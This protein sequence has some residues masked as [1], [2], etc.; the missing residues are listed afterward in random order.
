MS[1]HLHSIKVLTL[2]LLLAFVCL[3]QVNAQ[4][5]TSSV[6]GTAT[7][8][9]GILP[10]AVITLIHVP[11]GTQYATIANQ[12]GQFRLEGLRTGGPYRLEATYVGHNKTIVN[13]QRLLLGDV[14]EYDVQLEMENNL[15]EVVVAGNRA[16]E[17][18]DGS[19][20]N[21]SAEELNNIPS[22]DRRIEDVLRFSPYYQDG[23][24][25]SSLN[26]G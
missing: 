12:K 7:D 10:G 18:K 17:R 22:T 24:V 11:S 4:S 8:A 2:T 9:D 3:V 23:G 5:T 26:P 6:T 20:E 13:I 14:H 1:Y 19:S 16:A 25:F 15:R 21:F